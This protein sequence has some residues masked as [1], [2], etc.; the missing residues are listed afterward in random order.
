MIEQRYKFATHDDDN[1][2]F[3]HWSTKIKIA[4]GDNDDIG[5]ID[6]AGNDGK[7]VHTVGRIMVS[8]SGE[9]NGDDDLPSV[10]RFLPHANGGVSLTERMR[11]QLKW[12][13]FNHYTGNYYGALNVEKTSTSSTFIRFQQMEQTKVLVDSYESIY[14]RRS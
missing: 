7:V 1:P 14:I 8:S 3:S 2:W 10:M 6:F 11:L 5:Q 9:G 13:T 12:I 4:L